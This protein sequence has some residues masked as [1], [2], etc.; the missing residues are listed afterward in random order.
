MQKRNERLRDALVLADDDTFVGRHGGEEFLVVMPARSLD[1]AV[2]ELDAAR[3]VVSA[4]GIHTLDGSPL[5]CTISVGVVEA[6]DGAGSDGL[7]QVADA[8]LYEAKRRGRNQ[9]VAD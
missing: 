6:G 9:V 5:S 8:R 3:G 2:R 7:L 4:P 1:E